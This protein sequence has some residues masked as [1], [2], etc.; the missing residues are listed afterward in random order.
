MHCKL[1]TVGYYI[2]TVLSVVTYSKYQSFYNARSTGTYNSAIV[3][4]KDHIR[5]W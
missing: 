4:D 1:K 5:H 2:H 3:A